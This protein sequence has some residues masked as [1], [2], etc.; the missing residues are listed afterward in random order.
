MLRRPPRSTLFPYT[1]LFRSPARRGPPAAATRLSD[2]SGLDQ[3]VRVE[4]ELLGRALVEVLVAVRR[5]V[6]RDHRGVDRLRDLRT[7]VEDHLHEAVVV[8]HHR[9]LAGGEA[10]GLRP[11]ET[12]LDRQRAVLGRLV[13]GARVAGH[14]QARDAE[15]AGHPR[16]VHDRVQHGR[17]GLVVGVR[18]VAA[19]LEADG[20][21]RRVHLGHAEE[22]LDL[23]LGVALGDIDRLAAEAT[24]L[25]K[26]LRDHVPDDHDRRPQQLGRVG[27]GQPDRAGTCD[28][29]RRPRGDPGRVA[30]V[31][32]RREDVRQHGQVED[33]VHRL[34]LVG[35]PQEV[36]VGVG[37]GDVLR[38]AADPAAHVDVAVRRARTVR[39]D[40][41]AHA[42]VAGLA[43]AA[44]AAGDVERHGA[45]IALL[46]EL[47][48]WSGLDHLAGDLVAQD[49]ALGGRR[50]AA[51]HVLVGAADVRRDDPEDRAVRELAA[52][53]R[54]VDAGAVLQLQGREVDVLDLDVARPH[55]GN[56]PVLSH[57]SLL[58]Y[59]WLAVARTYASRRGRPVLFEDA[60]TAPPAATLDL[61]RS[62][63]PHGSRSRP[64]PPAAGGARSALMGGLPGLAPPFRTRRSAYPGTPPGAL[65][66]IVSGTL[67]LYLCAHRRSA[68]TGP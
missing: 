15:L 28:V 42:R 36:P 12:D 63:T 30:A 20:I 37:H 39:I 32:P 53:I 13:H 35:E 19:S 46:D 21:D 17:R 68:A 26:S 31:V 55:I 16:H 8:L 27:R 50:A 48:P 7:V 33:L 9:T 54:G 52:D 3:A 65:I 22:L 25:L 49:Q 29:H 4:H 10:V 62:S 61:A 59:L 40:V 43:H 56:T 57:V 44:A 51:D 23:V 34:F 67:S 41:Q 1:T 66:E 38:L 64:P 24:R 45:E 14:V 2:L 60:L 47:H 18:A 5:L 11:A 6:Q 58:S